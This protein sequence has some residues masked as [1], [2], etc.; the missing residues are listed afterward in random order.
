MIKV[1]R[2][3]SVERKRRIAIIL[4]SLCEWTHEYYVAVTPFNTNNPHEDL[5]RFWCSEA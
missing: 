5:R 2:K 3:D 1:E 4:K